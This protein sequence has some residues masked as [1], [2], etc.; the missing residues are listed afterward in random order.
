MTKP[1]ENETVTN[2]PGVLPADFTEARDQLNVLGPMTTSTEWERAA[3]VWAL[4]EPQRGGDRRS[5]AYRTN[6]ENPA[7][8]G[9]I[10]FSKLAAW[11]CH[12]LTDR[13]TVAAYWK[14]WNDAIDNHLAELAV[15]GGPYVQPHDQAGKQVEWP[16]F[17]HYKGDPDSEPKESPP[18]K[19]SPLIYKAIV[20]V[21]DA[22]GIAWDENKPI[23]DDF[24]RRV[25]QR[26]LDNLTGWVGRYQAFADG[27]REGYWAYSEA[28]PFPADIYEAEYG[29]AIPATDKWKE[30][31]EY[32]HQ[33]VR[34][35]RRP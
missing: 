7:L 24:E 22:F 31:D 4:T 33:G 25:L 1:M 2:T 13:G 16:G 3:I 29:V 23:T 5:E 32:D 14:Y 27:G 9:K 8:V 28:H 30:L 12:G 11:G 15:L 17:R 18:L 34:H 6:A 20:A 10:S 26:Q 19:T 21:V 35:P